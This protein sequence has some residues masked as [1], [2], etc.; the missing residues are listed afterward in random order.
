MA[1]VTYD[2]PLVTRLRNAFT[3][4]YNWVSRP[5]QTKKFRCT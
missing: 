4:I 1:Q 3:Q 2:N 5:R